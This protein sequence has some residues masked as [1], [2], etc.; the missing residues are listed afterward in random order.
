VFVDNRVHMTTEPNRALM[1]LRRPL[2]RRVPYAAK[3]SAA[4][5][6]GSV[7]HRQKTKRRGLLKE[8]SRVFHGMKR[9]TIITARNAMLRLPGC[10]SVLSPLAVMGSRPA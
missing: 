7:G 5:L 3:V 2:R 1:A 10:S 8:A 9:A 4:V 6:T